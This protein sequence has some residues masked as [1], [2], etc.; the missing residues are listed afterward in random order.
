MWES[1]SAARS[2]FFGDRVREY[3]ERY[4]GRV[5]HTE[6]ITVRTAA[7]EAASVPVIV[8]YEVRP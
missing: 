2:T 6:S 3:A 4:H 7:G 1:F 5:V 8:V